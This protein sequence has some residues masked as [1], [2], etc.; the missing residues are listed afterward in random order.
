MSTLS[1]RE[2]TLRRALQ[3]AAASIEPAPDGLERIQARLR[4]P[5]PIVVGWLEA[6]WTDFFLR[7]RA[8]LQTAGPLVADAMRSAWERFGPAAEAGRGR[9]LRWL[10]PLAA[11]SL[12]IFV[13][14]AGTY[15]GL[16]SSALFPVGT[17][18]NSGRSARAR[19]NNGGPNSRGP[20]GSG[21]PVSTTGPFQPTPSPT[22]CTKTPKA[23]YVAPNSSP[24]SSSSP[25]STGSP[26]PSGSSPTATPSP[27]STPSA[28]PNPADTT[29]GT[30]ADT[31]ASECWPG[32]RSSYIGGCGPDGHGDR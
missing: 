4:R 9:P 17:S 10:R 12:A 19:S 3:R 28:T 6:A 31:G 26:S 23:H 32:P 18:L 22:A 5:R 1:E 13:V 2:A 27:S 8:A 14:A 29:S 20:Y 15:V 11:L 21:S 24:S 25:A 7:A 16:N 30:G